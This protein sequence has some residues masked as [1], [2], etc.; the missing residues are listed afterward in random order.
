MISRKRSRG[1]SACSGVFM[2]CVLFLFVCVVVLIDNFDRDIGDSRAEIPDAIR[3]HFEIFSNRRMRWRDIANDG[4]CEDAWPA[5]FLFSG[6][7]R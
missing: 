4:S 2:F 3:A 6:V 7:S 1:K 5:R